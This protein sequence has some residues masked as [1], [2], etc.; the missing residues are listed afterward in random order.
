MPTSS[1]INRV[2]KHLVSLYSGLK[3]ASV[4]DAMVLVE[5]PLKFEDPGLNSLTLSLRGYV[6]F[7]K[8]EN[9][10]VLKEVK[11]KGQTVAGLISIV[12]EKI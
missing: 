3:E 2:V 6:K 1:E 12:K 5:A 8:P 9:T 10:I 7:F 11:K 4:S